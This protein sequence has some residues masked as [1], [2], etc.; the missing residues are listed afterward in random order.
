MSIS[1]PEDLALMRRD[2][3]IRGLEIVLVSSRLSEL[4]A[5]ASGGALCGPVVPDYVRYKPGTSCIVG[6]RARVDN[7]EVPCFALAAAPHAREKLDTVM[8]RHAGR[9]LGG[10][11]PTLDRERR[12]VVGSLSADRRVRALEHLG[13]E[14]WPQ[15]L[16]RAGMRVVEG[17]PPQLSLLSYRP[18]RRLVARVER[19]GQRLVARLYAQED[20]AFERAALALRAIGGS[21]VTPRRLGRSRRHRIL[22]HDWIGGSTYESLAARGEL[23]ESHLHALG[24]ALADLHAI[25]APGLAPADDGRRRLFICALAVATLLPREQGRAF[26]IARSVGERAMPGRTVVLHGDLSLDQVVWTGRR[27]VFIDL[28]HARHGVPAE[29]FASLAAASRGSGIDLGPVAAGYL[30]AGG[31]TLGDLAAF[32]AAAHLQRAVEP[33]RRRVD[34]WA[35][36]V[37][38][39]LDA[40]QR[41]LASGG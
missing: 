21:S 7:S 27:A 33:F 31:G 8:R 20:R 2:P 1:A 4:A 6:F 18:E 30:A 35:D 34:G 23:A 38:A 32:R 17:A 22:M 40:A 10:I 11:R 24:A 13:T 39:H 41:E 28:D 25:S 16:S 26:D 36:G 12:V 14:R 15:L 29:D 37:G 3:A 9:A 19:A 5:L